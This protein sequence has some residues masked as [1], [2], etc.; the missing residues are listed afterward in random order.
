MK[1]AKAKNK[2]NCRDQCDPFHLCLIRNHNWDKGHQKKMGPPIANQIPT[3]ILLVDS[4]LGG[5]PICHRR[6]F[7]S[8]DNFVENKRN[9]GFALSG[10]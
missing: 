8:A 2:P 10:S 5:A 4:P 6:P 7:S 9:E 1:H 3:L